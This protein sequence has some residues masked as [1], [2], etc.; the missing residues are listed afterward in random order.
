MVGSCSGLRPKIGSGF[1]AASKAALH[2]LTG[3]LAVELAPSGILVN[4]V[5]PGTV[6]TPMLEGARTPREGMLYTS[7]GES[8][9]GRIAQSD[10]IADVILFL[11][12]DHAKYVNGSI[13]PVDGGNRA[14][15]Y[16][17][18]PVPAQVA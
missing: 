18:L 4:A 11:L 13:I 12:G 1:Y 17:E 8:P 2:V 5:A 15:F 10:D 9:L 14:A 7:S 3:V 6:A 16:R